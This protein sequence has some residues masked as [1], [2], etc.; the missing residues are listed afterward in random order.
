MD[1][2]RA[3]AAPSPPQQLPQ[4][5]PPAPTVDLALDDTTVTHRPQSLTCLPPW[6]H[7]DSTAPL[8]TLS[9]ES[10]KLLPLPCLLPGDRV[11]SVGGRRVAPGGGGAAVL[12]EALQGLAPVAPPAPLAPEDPDEVSAAPVYDPSVLVVVRRVSSASRGA[13]GDPTRSAWAQAAGGGVALPAVRKA[14]VE[15]LLL[16]RQLLNFYPEP[17]ARYAVAMACRLDAIALAGSAETLLAA[18]GEEHRRLM[19]GL[20]LDLSDDHTKLPRFLLP[21]NRSSVRG[22]APAAAA[23]AGAA[24]EGGD[25]EVIIID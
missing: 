5:K 6:V 14:V 16:E 10:G 13:E 12:T 15:L 21:F 2:V 20:F 25:D 19:E 23:E 8:T 18:L 3:S 1:P 11:M 9:K 22:G 4:P 17:G 7:P 24:A